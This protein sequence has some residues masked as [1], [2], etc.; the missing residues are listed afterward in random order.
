[1]E[2]LYEQVA[3][4]SEL[5]DLRADLLS[6]AFWDYV[7]Q[8]LKSVV[9]VAYDYKGIGSTTFQSIVRGLFSCTGDENVKT[10][11]AKVSRELI[12]ILQK[13]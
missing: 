11:L 13:E 8:E 6:E 2:K 3:D 12:S 5:L 10:K 4:K 9:F 7:L 1:M